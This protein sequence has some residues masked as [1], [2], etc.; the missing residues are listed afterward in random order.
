MLIDLD[1]SKI[2]TPRLWINSG[3]DGDNS[4]YLKIADNYW[5]GD[6]YLR[7]AKDNV[8]MGKWTLLNDGQHIGN[9]KVNNQTLYILH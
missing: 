4:F 2:R 6:S 1:D 8:M 9:G 7:V 3:T 5:A